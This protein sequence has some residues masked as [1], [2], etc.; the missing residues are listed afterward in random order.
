MKKLV[1]A[2]NMLN[3]RPQLDEWFENMSRIADYILIVD[4]GSKDGTIEFFEARTSLVSVRSCVDEERFKEEVK[5]ASHT[6]PFPIAVIVDN[7]IQREG[8]GPSRNHLREASKRHF[9]D[10]H[11]LAYF[12]ADERILPEDF[13]ELRFLKDN[14]IDQFDVVAF[15]R[16]DW[17]DKEMSKAA[18]DWKVY[19]DFQARMTRLDS[20][21]KYVRRLHEQITNHK[22]IFATINNPKIHHF[23]RSAGQD[24]RDYIGKVCAFLHQKDEYGHTY[25]EHH[26]E[27]HYRELLEKEGL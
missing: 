7:I 12:D 21:C 13:F 27:A 1:V 15:P 22:N 8:Y 11:W 9:P 2:S 16:I 5:K 20:P 23:H 14:L 25:P 17:L 24:K 6:Q 18:K 4:G 10:A 3:E 26:K 19:P